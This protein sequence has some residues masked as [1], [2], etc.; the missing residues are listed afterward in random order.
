MFLKRLFVFFVMEIETR[1]VHVL[2]VTANP[3]G[4]WTTQQ[5][6][7][8]LMDLG[9]RAGLVTMYMRPANSRSRRRRNPGTG[10]P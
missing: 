6:R 10:V 5:A 2:G 9:E 7:N 8:L 1:R 3:T 4:S